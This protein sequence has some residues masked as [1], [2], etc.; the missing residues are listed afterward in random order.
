MNQKQLRIV[1]VMSGT[2]LDGLDL[3]LVKFT[4]N[5]TSWSYSIEATRGIPYEN[6]L[7]TRLED[8]IKLQA[9]NLLSF[10]ASYGTWLGEQ[11]REFL[12]DLKTSAD[13]IASHGH[14]IHH[15][16]EL[17]FTFQLGSP[18]HL[19]IACGL[20]VVGDF[21]SKDVALGGQGAPLVPIGDRI[22]FGAYDFCLNLGGISN[23]SF[24]SNK[25]RIAFD[26]GICNMLLNYLS[27]SAGC[28]YDK[29]GALARA[30][31]INTPL[32]SALDALPYY[33][34]SFPKSTGYEW[35]KSA[36]I[37]LIKQYPDTS[38]NLL[39][40]AAE[41]IAQQIIKQVTTLKSKREPN[42]LI[43]GGGARN[44]FLME[45]LHLHGKQ[46]M[47]WV[48]P[49]TELIDYKEALIFALLGALQLSGQTNVLASVT[50]AKRD[51][52]SGILYLP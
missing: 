28:N 31:H 45:L 10:H 52:C 26:I 36:V 39:R 44:T 21:R 51:S 35:F 42:V 47:H 38:E 34:Q 50:G 6:S 14:T 16:P 22:L 4:P 46:Q 29:G 18:Q 43:T 1:G 2:S 25:T 9:D 41:H 5:A 23:I 12:S 19:A 27:K 49:D 30:G 48:I 32:L 13:A 8:A 7:R 24:E 20:P 3:A 40:T 37:P 15:R 11:V 33:H 17:G